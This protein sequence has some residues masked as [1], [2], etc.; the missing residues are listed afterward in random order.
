LI[1]AISDSSHS[2]YRRR[3]WIV[4]ATFLLVF[5]GLGLAFT[6]PVAEALVDLFGGGQGDWDPRH[7]KLVSTFSEFSGLWSTSVDIASR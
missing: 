1:G 2:R 3:Y 6:E 4:T 7:A 5:S